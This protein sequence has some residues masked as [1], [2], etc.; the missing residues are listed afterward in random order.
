MAKMKH[1]RRASGD[2]SNARKR[3]S[4]VLETEAEYGTKLVAIAEHGRVVTLD[5]N[6]RCVVC[7]EDL[8]A[9]T[10]ALSYPKTGD[11]AHI[12]WQCPARPEYRNEMI[13]IP[14]PT[15]GPYEMLGHTC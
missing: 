13:V 7:E 15:A 3:E 8:A 6:G 4:V 5:A 10:E 14:L 12:R 1:H 2:V 11:L 9:G